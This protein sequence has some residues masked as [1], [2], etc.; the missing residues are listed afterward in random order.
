MLMLQVQ[1]IEKK[2][3][4]Q[5][6]MRKLP[7]WG[8]VHDHSKVD[9]QWPTLEI[10]EAM[11]PDTRLKTILVQSDNI[12]MDRSISSL[13]LIF[14]N[15]V[16]SPLFECD[17]NKTKMRKLQ[18]SEQMKIA[19]VSSE[20][21]GSPISLVFNNAFGQELVSYNLHGQFEQKK[22][23]IAENEEII[24]VYGV[25]GSQSSMRSFGFI[26]KVKQLV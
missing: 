4:S 16:E 13:K 23:D 3:I 22:H 17:G 7:M 18:F 2:K 24:G 1:P 25:K 12:S 5:C 21:A 19:S 20:R 11:P 26:L 14:T 8:Q 9:F 10:F 15:N 6:Y